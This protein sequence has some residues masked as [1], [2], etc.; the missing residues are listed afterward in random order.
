MAEL[1]KDEKTIS[2]SYSLI[3]GGKY[4][5][6]IKHLLDLVKKNALINRAWKLLGI[7]FFR[8]GRY[9]EAIGYFEKSIELSPSEPF[10]YEEKAKCLMLSGEYPEAADNF[11]KASELST[12]REKV[13]GLLVASALCKMAADDKRAMENLRRAAEI[14]PKHTVENLQLIFDKI[15]LPMDIPKE[16]KLEI[17]T[18]INEIRTVASR[19]P[20]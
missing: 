15:I 19:R 16:K 13:T 8:L 18:S 5:V 6:A 7:A 1:S 17:Q 9:K 14:S 2:K 20:Y 11:Q 12:G 10:G 4:S 3:T